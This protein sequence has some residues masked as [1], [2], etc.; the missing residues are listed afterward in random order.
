[1]A[2]TTI[3]LDTYKQKIVSGD[4]FDIS[5]SF[6]GRVGDEQVPLEAHLYER[7]L[8]Q[9]FGDTL[10][11][12]MTGFVGERLD[13]ND[14]VTAA[15]GEAVSYVGTRAD[16][17]GLGKVK[18][19]LPGTMFPQEGY[20]YG[21]FGLETP[22]HSQRVS[23]F[24]VWFHV[25]GGNPDMFVNK[26][27]FRTEL[28]KIMDEGEQ[29]NQDNDGK[30]QTKLADWQKQVTDLITSSNTDFAKFQQT[31][32]NL[33]SSLDLIKDQIASNSVVTKPDLETQLATERQTT[34]K[35]VSDATTTANN[36]ADS[37][38]TDTLTQAN[39]HADSV[40]SDTLTKANSHA[41]G[42]GSSTLNQA[43][44]YA[45]NAV[46]NAV[47]S[48][49]GSGAFD[50]SGHFYGHGTTTGSNQVNWTRAGKQLTLMGALTPINTIPAGGKDTAFTVPQSVGL[51][52]GAN[53]A[54][55]QGTGNAIFQ[56]TV[57]EGGDAVIGRYRDTDSGAKDMTPGTWLPFTITVVLQ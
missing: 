43:N 35:A 21:F 56:L 3:K 14:Q 30:F 45:D 38:G 36:H 11:P 25:Y 55:E 19:S 26:A 53:F 32:D 37:V 41:D 5:D 47:Y 17:I 2:I 13:D 15:T 7:G 46:S 16:V 4:A 33:R 20:F 28:Q 51:V 40:E 8:P 34:D 23:T 39:N 9:Q 42:V 29:L 27:P 31:M 52:R 18:M 48:E 6:N 12:F 10:V 57:S 49:F 24:N 1:V 44:A 50:C 22:D 54:I